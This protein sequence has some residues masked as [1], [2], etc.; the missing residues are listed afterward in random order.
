VNRLG[1]CGRPGAWAIDCRG[2]R[3]V[4]DCGLDEA[5]SK[6]ASDLLKRGFTETAH[7]ENAGYGYAERSFVL[8]HVLLKAVYERGLTYLEV[9]CSLHPERLVEASGF[10][11]LIDPPAQGRW[12]LGMGAAAFLNA[13]WER[14]YDLLRPSNWMQ[15]R[16]E[17]EAFHTARSG[18]N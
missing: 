13:H 4:V 12:N 3:R 17:I 5:V 2:R 18:A 16:D 14:V 9:G 11:D 6:Y 15:T 10:R 1:I 8:D 7:D